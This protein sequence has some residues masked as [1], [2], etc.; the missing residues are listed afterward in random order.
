MLDP[1]PQHW[2]TLNEI[3]LD[4]VLDLKLFKQGRYPA[5]PSETKL[6]ALYSSG[7]YLRPTGD[8][9]QW[10]RSGYGLRIRLVRSRKLVCACSRSCQIWLECRKNTFGIFTYQ[11]FSGLKKVA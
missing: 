7:S 9:G 10:I 8:P 1:D 3:G 4:S 6:A 11:K 2:P 5:G